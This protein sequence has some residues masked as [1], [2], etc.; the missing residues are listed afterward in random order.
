V[1]AWWPIAYALQR[2][3]DPRAVPALRELV[4]TRGVYTASFAARGLGAS[5]DPSVGRVLLDLLDPA[6]HPA[7]VVVVAIRG[8]ASLD[9]A[10]AAGPLARVAASADAHP[11]LRLEAVRAL[12]ALRAP[13][14]EPIVQDLLTDPWP[15]MR[16]E[17]L[18]AASLIDREMFALVLSGLDPDAHWSVRAAL[19]DVLA[20]MPADFGIARLRDM[21]AD[22]DKRVIP[23]VLNALARHRVP[24][25]TTILLN[26]LKDSDSTVREAAARNLGEQKPSGAVDALREAFKKGLA[27]ADYSA[28]AAALTALAAYGPEAAE[29][30]KGALADNDWPVRLRAASILK[31]LTPGDDHTHAI[32]PAPGRPPMP[33]ADPQLIAPSFSHHAFIETAKGTIEIELAVLDAPQTAQ[34]FIALARKGFFNGLAFHRVV[35]NFVIQD[36]DP[37]GDGGG[38]P[39]YTIRDELNDRPYLRGTVGMALSRRDDGGSQFFITHSPQPHLDG[40]YTAFGHV[41]NGMEIVDRIQ[42]GDVIQRI[43][44]WDGKTMQ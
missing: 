29:T 12:G 27:D 4:R 22:E 15:A 35:P 31:R 26:H 28:R 7:E 37:R 10:D 24:D 20:S 2:I 17:A 13:S 32:R 3:G 39:G 9:A 19:A 1:S 16:A 42:Q 14:A 34:N 36:G 44:I 25:L 8:V 21:L 6:K 33:Y 23:A 18:R 5:K 11:N 40:R 43:R 30:I 41:V 38:G